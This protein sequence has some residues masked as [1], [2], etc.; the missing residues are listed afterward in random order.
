M[1]EWGKQLEY[2]GS[3]S[4]SDIEGT[5]ARLRNRTLLNY[6]STEAPIVP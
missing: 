3:G 2:E 5:G 6:P 1:K 4:N